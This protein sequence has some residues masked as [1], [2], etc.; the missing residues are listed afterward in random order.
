MFTVPVGNYNAF[1]L[2]DILISIDNK[3]IFTLNN[4]NGKYTITSNFTVSV[5]N[6]ST[7]L[8]II[9]GELNK[10]YNGLAVN[11]K[12]ILDFPFGVNLHIQQLVKADRPSKCFMQNHKA[13]GILYKLNIAKAS[14]LGGACSAY[15]L[16]PTI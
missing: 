4:S 7:I 15:N 13:F 3:I 12:Y 5:L 10:T 16:K 6:T 1:T 11:N 2:L 14:S 9:G 8:K